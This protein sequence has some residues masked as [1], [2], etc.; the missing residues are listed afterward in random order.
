ML[1]FHNPEEKQHMEMVVSRFK[2]RR[3][4]QTPES[5]LIL[6]HRMFP[7]KNTDFYWAK[8]SLP[9]NTKIFQ[10]FIGKWFF[11]FI[12]F[13]DPVLVILYIEYFAMLKK[14]YLHLLPAL[15]EDIGY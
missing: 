14:E 3:L 5:L 10:K 12:E 9:I 7:P 11:I 8:W 1:R 2:V 13:R 4:S 15:N 6:G